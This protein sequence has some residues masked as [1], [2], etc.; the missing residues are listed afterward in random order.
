MAWNVFR[1][2]WKSNKHHPQP[3]QPMKRPEKFRR[4]QWFALGLLMLVLFAIYN[5]LVAPIWQFYHETQDNM[6]DTAFR[7][8]RYQAIAAQKDY[9]QHHLEELRK[10]EQE[11]AQLTSGATP[12]LASAELQTFIKNI[13]TD[14]EGELVSTQVLPT[15]Q[16][17]AFTRIAVKIRLN[18]N[19]TT[20][21]DV[22]YQIESARPLRFVENLNIR[23]I[24]NQH[25]PVTKRFEP[26]DRLS[27]DFDVIAYMRTG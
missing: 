2:P 3:P 13:V 8:Q 24:R 4:G 25:N 17:D 6:E 5:S 20:L 7:L 15:K 10:N 11:N 23:P 26:T 16:D 22:L 19:M 27:V 1:L 14:A 18:G 9:W 12:A 21:R